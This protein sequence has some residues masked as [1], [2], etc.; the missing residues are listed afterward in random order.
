MVYCQAPQYSGQL[1]LVH[2]NAGLFQ[3]C[4]ASASTSTSHS[5]QSWQDTDALPIPR[6][7][8]IHYPLQCSYCIYRLHST[9]NFTFCAAIWPGLAV[10]QVDANRVACCSIIFVYC[11]LTC[12]RPDNINIFTG[13]KQSSCFPYMGDGWLPRCAA[14]VLEK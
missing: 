13:I 11:N 14:C 1:K 3:L 4:L 2:P 10:I 7:H 8:T 12:R 6:R 9:R 5:H